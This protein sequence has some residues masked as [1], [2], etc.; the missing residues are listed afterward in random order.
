MQWFINWSTSRKL[1]AA[2]GLV[3]AMAVLVGVFGHSSLGE[4]QDGEATIYSN[5]ATPLAALTRMGQ[6]FQQVRVAMRDAVLS[7]SKAQAELQASRI[8]DLTADLN[9]QSEAFERSII[10]DNVRGAFSEFKTAY[11]EFGPRR[12]R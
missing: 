1:L 8:K 10:R 2:F 12:D 4:I 7:S 6:T 3:G 9:A 11:Q 5:I